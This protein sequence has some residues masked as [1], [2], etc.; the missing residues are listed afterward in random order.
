MTRHMTPMIHDRYRGNVSRTRFYLDKA[1]A[2]PESHHPYYASARID[3]ALT[4]S[5]CSDA[6]MSVIVCPVGSAGEWGSPWSDRPAFNLPPHLYRYIRRCSTNELGQIVRWSSRY[7]LRT[8]GG[9]L[10]LLAIHHYNVANRRGW[11]RK[12]RL[13]IHGVGSGQR[14]MEGLHRRWIEDADF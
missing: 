1:L 11:L 4:L 14:R 9:H 6:N 8:V 5:Y 10:Y 13:P 2:D 12:A 7:P 3:R